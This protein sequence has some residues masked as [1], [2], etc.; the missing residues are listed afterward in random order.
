MP[1]DKSNRIK[2]VEQLIYRQLVMLIRNNVSDPRIGEMSITEVQVSKDLEHAKVFYTI[3]DDNDISRKEC[4]SALVKA[5]GYIRTLLSKAVDLRIT[6]ELKFVYDD[7]ALKGERINR[8][9]DD[10]VK[11]YDNSK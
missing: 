6:P 2:R 11:K 4:Q 9:I 10:A 3:L 7:S 5:K 8:L 1:A